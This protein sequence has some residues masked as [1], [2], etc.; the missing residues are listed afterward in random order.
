MPT[1]KTKICENCETE[2]G[3]NEESCPKCGVN[4]ADLEDEVKVVTR[5]H[6]VAEKRRKKTEPVVIANPT[7]EKKS[8]FKSL[9][10]LAS[11]KPAV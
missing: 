7:P 9:A 3:I 6:A 5:A 10:R 11:G 4:F 8:I 2:I 1:E